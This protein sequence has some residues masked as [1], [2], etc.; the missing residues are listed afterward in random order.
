[1]FGSASPVPAK[2]RKVIPGNEPR[3]L[4]QLSRFNYFPNSVGTATHER[5]RQQH[6]SRELF[7]LYVDINFS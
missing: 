5:L 7:S 4:F 3:M 1:M 6:Q 2:C